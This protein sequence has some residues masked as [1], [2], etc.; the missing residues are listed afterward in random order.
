MTNDEY[1]SNMDTIINAFRMFHL[2]SMG[3][4]DAELEEMRKTLAIADSVGCFIDPT[5]YRKSLQ[6]G[7]LDR[8]KAVLEL[9]KTVRQ[10]L[11]KA[12]PSQWIPT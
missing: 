1:K 6:D 10:D 8:Q 5:A 4:T 7:S 3:V 12:F 9:V 11:S 2:L